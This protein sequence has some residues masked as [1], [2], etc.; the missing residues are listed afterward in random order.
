VILEKNPLDVSGSRYKFVLDPINLFEKGRK[1]ALRVSTSQQT[2]DIDLSI[3]I[4]GYETI[5]T[6]TNPVKWVY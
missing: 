6:L 3:K 4:C 1:Y 2:M 5:R